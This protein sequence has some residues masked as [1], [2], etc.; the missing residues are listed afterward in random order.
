MPIKGQTPFKTKTSF[1]AKVWVTKGLT[2]DGGKRRTNSI[3]S[4]HI[5]TVQYQCREGTNNE[6]QDGHATTET[7]TSICKQGVWNCYICIFS[8]N[9]FKPSDNLMY[10]LL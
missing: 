10:H 5:D 1:D 9:P 8:F 3:G 6:I 4:F 7:F 2:K